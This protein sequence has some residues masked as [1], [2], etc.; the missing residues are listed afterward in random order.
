MGQWEEM[1][2]D[3]IPMS[4]TASMAHYIR[5][6]TWSSYYGNPQLIQAQ[7]IILEVQES[8]VL[9]ASWITSAMKNDMA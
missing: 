9:S 5:L 8:A 6:L 2:S 1:D 4:K 7:K 3:A